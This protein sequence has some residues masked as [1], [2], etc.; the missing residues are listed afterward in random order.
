MDFTI[1][2]EERRGYKKT[3]FRNLRMFHG[4]CN[5]GKIKANKLRVNNDGIRW[6]FDLDS[7]E[8]YLSLIC[9]KCKTGVVIKDN[10]GSFRKDILS[11]AVD[12]Q[13][14]KG[15]EDQ[16]RIKANWLIYKTTHML[17]EVQFTISQIKPEGKPE[18]KLEE[19]VG[20]KAK[21]T[22]RELKD[23]LAKVEKGKK[24]AEEKA[25]KTTE[26]LRVAKKQLKRLKEKIV[27]L[28]KDKR[29]PD[30]IY[31][32][33]CGTKITIT[34]SSCPFCGVNIEERIKKIEKVPTYNK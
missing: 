2:V 13:E 27:Q 26:K 32:P 33:S 3:K 19:E 6:L 34:D 9:E 28:E 1:N 18:E 4:E 20:R 11:T 16:Y 14:R 5:E 17:N 25:K 21:K 23:K 30:E 31:C 22:I 12:G 15:R 10:Y 29:E 24:E 8:S 7:Y